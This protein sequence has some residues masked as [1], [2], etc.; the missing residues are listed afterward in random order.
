MA[1]DITAAVNTM[2]R[3][4]KRYTGDGLPGE[5]TGAPLPVGDPQSGPYS[6]KKSELRA[7]FLA[8]LG[9]A[10]EDSAA[11]EA[12]LAELERIYLGAKASDPTTD[13]EGGE[14]ITGAI[15]FNTT[16]GKMRVW[17]AA[18]IWQ[19][20]STAIGDGDVTTAKIANLA[21]ATGKIADGAV[22][23]GKLG[24]GAVA[25]AKIAD[26]AVT[27]AKL[28]AAAVEALS[29]PPRG[30]LFGLTLANNAS[31]ATNDLD[32]ASGE[33]ASDAS[34]PAL[35][36]LAASITKRLDA[37]WAVGGGNGGLDTGVIANTTYH[38]FLI[39]RPDT[40]VVD[41]L[42]SASATSPTLPTNYTQ[43]RRI[44][45]FVRNSGA[46]RAFTQRGDRFTYFSP[47]ADVDVSNLAA[48]PGTT[49]TLASI[50]TGIQ[51][52]AIITAAMSNASANRNGLVSSLDQ[53]DDAPGNSGQ[54][55]MQ[56]SNQFSAASLQIRTNTS[57]QIRARSDS[58]STSLRVSVVGFIDT[59]GRV[60]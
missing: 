5:P 54:V 28:A 57:A 36:A 44:G 32:I 42:F 22:T 41:V 53:S 18:D 9:P 1:I 34:S 39:R 2:F 60:S 7:A 56:L 59:R 31:D 38:V 24:T 49:Y 30:H 45:S 20:Q 11:A 35:M 33:A 13:N 23:G 26:G 15:Y 25:E 27:L 58:D 19:N 51:V 48:A 55:W 10:A 12:A 8:V 16:D 3:E 17:T 6:A 29:T 47:R 21:V 43:K 4:F 50:P 52:D 14:L 37:A 40:G 46:I